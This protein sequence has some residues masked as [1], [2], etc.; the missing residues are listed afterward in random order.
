[1]LRFAVAI[2]IGLGFLAGPRAMAQMP[3]EKYATEWGFTSGGAIDLPGG[4]FGGEF[5]AT[6]FRWGKI[7]TAPHG[8]GPFRGTFEYAFEIV[9]AIVLRQAR[10]H[11]AQPGGA[12]FGGG[13]TPL[14]FQW[15]FTSSQ[16]IVPFFQIAGGALWTTRDFPHV[17][18][19]FNFTPQGGLGAYWFVRPQRAVSFGVRF[20]HISNA[21]ITDP[22]P[23]HNALYFYAG[24]SWWR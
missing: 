15:N 14:V 22:N 21:G 8:P 12:L 16:Q 19:S 11:P 10:F 17:G 5:W 1:M 4:A 7:L 3:A 9:P 13:F 6:Q 24:L 20:H 23:G 18:S 2:V